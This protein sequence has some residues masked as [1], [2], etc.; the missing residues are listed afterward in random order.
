MRIVLHKRQCLNGGTHSHSR[1]RARSYAR[2]RTTYNKHCQHSLQKAPFPTDSYRLQNI[3]V[4]SYPVSRKLLPHCVYL[5]N[6][7][8]TYSGTVFATVRWLGVRV[9]CPRTYSPTPAYGLLRRLWP[10]TSHD[11]PVLVSD[12]AHVR[13]AEPLGSVGLNRFGILTQK[14]L[15]QYKIHTNNAT[16]R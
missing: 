10:F 4:N 11:F 2:S 9:E 7:P 6:R 3:T 12:R 15:I 1:S 14:R 8:I 5:R 13:I 16:W